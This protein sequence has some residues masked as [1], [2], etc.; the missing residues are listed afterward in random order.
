MLPQHQRYVGGRGVN[1]IV[2]KSWMTVEEGWWIYGI[3]L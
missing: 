1:E 3:L 2:G